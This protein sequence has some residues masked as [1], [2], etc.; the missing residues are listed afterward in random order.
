ML[1]TLLQQ[2]DEKIRVL[3]SD[4]VIADTAREKLSTKVNSLEDTVE[5]LRQQ[6]IVL[7]SDLVIADTAREKLSTKVN[8]L[9]GTVET[10]RQQNIHYEDLVR[11]LMKA[12]ASYRE[13]VE[14]I[15]SLTKQLE[16]ARQELMKSENARKGL[17][18]E[19]ETLVKIVK[20]ERDERAK[21][22]GFIAQL[23]GKLQATKEQLCTTQDK[24]GRSQGEVAQLTE[25]NAQHEEIIAQQMSELHATKEQLSATQTDLTQTER[26]ARD[27]QGELYDKVESIG[28]LEQQLAVTQSKLDLSQRELERALDTLTATA[29]RLQEE[30]MRTEEAVAVLALKEVD[31]AGL[32]EKL[33]ETELAKEHLLTEMSQALGTVKAKCFCNTMTRILHR[34]GNRC[35]A[36]ALEAWCS[37]T[38]HVR[39]ASAAESHRI[40]LV[41]RS[42]KRMLNKL[43]ASAFSTIHVNSWDQNV[44]R[45]NAQRIVKRLRNSA[46]NRAFERW[47]E[48][49]R[50]L[51]ETN[52]CSRCGNRVFA[53]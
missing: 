51:K 25:T 49:T 22:L 35:A 2:R 39:Y 19:V 16:G 48:H 45:L 11:H 40:L 47:Y 1:D 29:E 12:E 36:L 7:K 27:L 38:E 5:I 14:S 10:L 3:K 44:M 33:K 42:L 28:V 46:V 6:N 20:A 21:A 41:R 43:L 30:A 18:A 26:T 53:R 13:T 4:L 9:E 32:R 15:S 52:C 17:E 34:L 8:S 37:H 23:E 31:I 50:E 24:L